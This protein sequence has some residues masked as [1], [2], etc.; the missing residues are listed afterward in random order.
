M[1]QEIN[2]DITTTHEEINEKKKKKIWKPVDPEYFKKYYHKH[3]GC[4]EYTCPICGKTLSNNQKIK[5]HETSKACQSA[6]QL[7]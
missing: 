3:Y 5:R 4:N 2:N 1:T 7:V 6:K